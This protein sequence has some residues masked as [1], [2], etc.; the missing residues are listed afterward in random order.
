MTQFSGLARS[1]AAV[2]VGRVNEYSREWT[3]FGVFMGLRGAPMPV[4]NA[5]TAWETV[6]QPTINYTRVR[7]LSRTVLF[8]TILAY[9][10]RSL[11]SAREGRGGPKSP[12][13]RP[14]IISAL[15]CDCFTSASSCLIK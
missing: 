2:V 15:S 3:R 9:L 5:S 7:K 1:L 11:K 6:S 14:K 4:P 10:L 12:D 8:G 13:N